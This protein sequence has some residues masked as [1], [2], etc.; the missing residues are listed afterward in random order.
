VRPTVS[1]VLVAYNA[2]WCI[3]RALAA[4]IAQTSSA[5]EV[6][7]CDDGSVD[8]TADLVEARFG[9]PVRVLRLPHRSASVSRSVGLA[10]ARGDWLSFLDAD[11]WWEPSKLE[12]QLDYIERHPDIRWLACDGE[13]VSAERVIRESWLADYFDPVRELHGNLFPVLMQRCFPLMSSVMVHRDA[14]AAVGGLDQ[15]LALSHDYD[16]WLRVMA[17]YPA[18]LM[19]DRLVHYWYH[20]G[21]LSRRVEARHRDDLEIMERV[22]RGQVRPDAATRRLGRVR[23]AALAFDIGLMCLRDRRIADARELFGRAMGAGPLRRRAFALAG[24]MMPAG[25]VPTVLRMNWL[26]GPVA[27]ARAH[28]HMIPPGG[29]AA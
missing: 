26:K 28:K 6:L 10:A 29:G 19:T 24:R 5:H 7:V 11:D 3:E 12:R 14:Y 23:A 16:L 9:P 4:V 8:G 27:G 20:E 21:A 15:T 2:A 17:R 13:F 25:L 22:A 1:V 18:A